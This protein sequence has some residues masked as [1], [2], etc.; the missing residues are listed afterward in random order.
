MDLSIL[1]RR[2]NP[3]GEA[4]DYISKMLNAVKKNRRPRTF[5]IGGNL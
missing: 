1:F 3:Q 4:V 5:M 2:K